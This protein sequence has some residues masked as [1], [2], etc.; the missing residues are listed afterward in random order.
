MDTTSTTFLVL[1]L[2]GIFAFALNRG[3]DG[4]R[5]VRLDIVGVVRL[6]M[7]TALGGGVVRDILL[8]ALPPATSGIG[9]T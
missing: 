5:V 9:A 8:G 7:F 4:I 1:D 3:S 2:T 6:G